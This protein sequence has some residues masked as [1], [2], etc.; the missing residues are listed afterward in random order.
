MMKKEKILETDSNQERCR[1][2]LISIRK[3]IQ[4]IDIHSS[5]LN[6]QYGLTGPQIIVLH[7]IN[8][9]GKISITPL[10]RATNLSQA[11]TTVIVKRLEAKGYIYRKNRE[12]DRR[13]V[14]LFLTNEGKEIAAAHPPLLQEEFTEKFSKIENW[15]Q[16]MIMTA[17]ERVVSLMSAQEIDASPI[18]VTGPIQKNSKA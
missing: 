13:S 1:D 15:E 5:K 9:H 2:L 6:R 18:L 7:E 17:F 8:N 14:S 11:T 10:A 12:D 3:I 4:A 16:L